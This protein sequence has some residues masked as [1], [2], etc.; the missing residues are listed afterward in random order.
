MASAAAVA[1]QLRGQFAFPTH[2]FSPARKVR[3]A[4]S[5][6]TLELQERVVRRSRRHSMNRSWTRIACGEQ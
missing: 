5:L 1:E 6:R 3:L 2:I 4:L